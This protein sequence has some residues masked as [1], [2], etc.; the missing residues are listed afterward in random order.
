[1]VFEYIFGTCESERLQFATV[2]SIYENILGLKV[3]GY[4]PHKK[5]N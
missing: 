5:P 4:W 2:N 1:M 3:T